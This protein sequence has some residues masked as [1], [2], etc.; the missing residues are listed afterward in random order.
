M[1]LYFVYEMWNKYT[2]FVY[3]FGSIYQIMSEEESFEIAVEKDLR[4]EWE[5]STILH[6]RVVTFSQISTWHGA[7]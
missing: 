4:N 2:K 5:I 1:S 3:D 7:A 6:T